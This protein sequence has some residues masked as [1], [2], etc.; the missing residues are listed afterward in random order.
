MVAITIIKAQLFPDACNFPHD[1]P[2]TT[3]RRKRIIISD[4]T[5]SDASEMKAN[6]LA[7]ACSDDTL[8]GTQIGTWKVL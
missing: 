6:C 5:I 7:S 4:C 8:D 3:L 1:A 2:A